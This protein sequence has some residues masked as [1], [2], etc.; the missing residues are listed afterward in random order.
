MPH[1]KYRRCITS[2]EG[3]SLVVILPRSIDDTR[4]SNNSAATISHDLYHLLEGRA[5][6]DHIF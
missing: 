1:A 5:L 2:V 3:N 4:N 6:S